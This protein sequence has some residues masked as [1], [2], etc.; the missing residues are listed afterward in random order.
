MLVNVI[1]TQPLTARDQTITLSAGPLSLTT[2]IL[3]PADADPRDQEC[4]AVCGVLSKS[5]AKVVRGARS[6]IARSWPTGTVASISSDGLMYERSQEPTSDDIAPPESV[7]TSRRP[8]LDIAQTTKRGACPH[9][10]RTD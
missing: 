6:T 8:A 7:R 1:L 3:I 4:L 5:Q 9:C 2:E 10:G